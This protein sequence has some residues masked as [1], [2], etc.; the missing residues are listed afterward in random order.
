MHLHKHFFFLVALFAFAFLA[1]AQQ[2]IKNEGQWPEPFA[3]KLEFKDVAVFVSPTSM[4]INLRDPSAFSHF[5]NEQGEHVLPHYPIKHHGLE[6]IFTNNLQPAIIP[7][8]KAST[9]HNYFL[10]KDPSRWKGNVPLYNK[11][12]VQEL[13]PGISMHLKPG[14]ANLK[15]DLIIQPNANPN[16]IAF[17]YNGADSLYLDQGRLI[18]L[19]SLGRVVEEAPIAWQIIDGKVENVDVA[20]T[21]KANQVGFKL[22]EYDETLELIIDP[23]Y[24]FSTYTGSTSDNFGYTA[25]YDQNGNTYGGGIVFNQGSYPTV[26]AFQ[27]TFQ[28]GMFDVS[29]SKFSPNG[30]SMIYSTYL[31]GSLNE[32]PHSMVVDNLGNLIVLGLTGSNNFP[33][34]SCAFDTSY[35]GGPNGSIGWAPFTQG[36]DIFITKFNAAGNALIGSTFL[37]GTSVDGANQT[38]QVNYGDAARGEVIADQ[39]GNIFFISSTGSTDFPTS[40]STVYQDTLAGGQD[41]VLGKLSSNLC[42]LLWSTYLGGNL[43]DAGYSLKL[44][45]AETTLFTCG[46]TRSDNFPSSANAWQT[47]RAGNTDGW[48]ASFNSSN[49]NYLAS[50]FNGTAQMDQNYFIELDGDDDVYVFGQTKGDYTVTPGLWGVTDGTQ[51][52]HKFNPNLQQSLRAITFGGGQPLGSR[53]V[54]ISPTALMVDECKSVYISGWGGL[55]NFEGSTN[56]L[57]VTPNAFDTITDGSDFYFLVLDGSWKFIE[58][59][60][61][62]GGSN[63]REHVDGGTSRFSPEGIIYQAVCAGCGGTSG[64]PAFPNNVVSTTNNSSNCNM[65]CLRIDFELQG[66]DVNIS[67]IPDSACLP[68]QLTFTDSSSNIDIMTWNFGDGTT[69]TGRTPNKVF[70]Q[71]GTYQITIIGADTLCNTSDTNTLTLH[72]FET[73]AQASFTANW[74]TCSLPFQVFLANQSVNATSF[75]WG[76]GDGTT[77]TQANPTKVYSNEGTYTIFLAVKDDFCN[78]WDTAY[79]TVTFKRP[80]GS[81]DFEARYEPCTDGTTVELIPFASGYQIYRWNFGDGDTSRMAVTTH[82][83]QNPGTYTITL[84]TKDT[85]CNVTRSTTREVTISN[86]KEIEEL[87][88]NVFTPN[89][90]DLNETWQLANSLDASQFE[91]LKVEVYNRWGQLVFSSNDAGFSWDGT[92][93]GKNLADA[94]YFWLAWYTDICG[95]E[96][97]QQGVVHIIR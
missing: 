33:V 2:F 20:F 12:I 89:N 94:V 43:N 61:F 47:S 65:A 5:H 36:S 6:V 18:I 42:N 58:Y 95:N 1:R 38:L 73:L 66:A 45:S 68:H 71:A 77:S 51:F 29:I 83:Y 14:L 80:A 23:N 37:G 82:T 9:Y 76:F 91:S 81:I 49:G 87:F 59:A 25:T 24:I 35:N 96:N 55:T 4:R 85:I 64:F 48:I 3:Y 34:T 79:T 22:G 27:D 21:L 28:G 50:T 74:D 41:A 57:P 10:G 30:T 60:T 70:N 44:N 11:L 78:T 16:N 7:T 69:Y 13:H 62:F 54:N 32:Q 56:N 40:G 67:L 52:I 88:P 26:G 72:V 63:S 90:D 92:F 84:V 97:A 53:L 75:V 17:T 15:Y 19:T 46:G 31:G 86:Y 8:E 39:N 93:E